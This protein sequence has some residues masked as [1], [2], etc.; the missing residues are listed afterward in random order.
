MM[1]ADVLDKFDSIKIATAYR[2]NGEVYDRIPYDIYA[3]IT[4]EY[5]EFKGWHK[6]L[7]GMRTEEELPFEFMN[8]VRFIEE[9]VGVPIKIISLGPD[10]GQ[11]IVRE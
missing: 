8:Y 3:D 10:R 2:I 11:T 4:P 5:K 9:S 1:K 7:E 6:S